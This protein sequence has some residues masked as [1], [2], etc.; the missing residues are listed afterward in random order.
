MNFNYKEEDCF[1]RGDKFLPAGLK[2]R[3]KIYNQVHGDAP[4]DGHKIRAWDPPLIPP[5]HPKNQS[6]NKNQNQA[7]QH[8]RP[9]SNAKT[10][11]QRYA[12]K[13]LVL[14][15]ENQNDIDEMETYPANDPSISALISEQLQFESDST[16]EYNEDASKPTICSFTNQ[17]NDMIRLIAEQHKFEYNFVDDER[18]QHFDILSARR[19]DDNDPPI[20]QHGDRVSPQHANIVDNQ[21]HHQNVNSENVIHPTQHQ[22]AAV[23]QELRNY[24]HNH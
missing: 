10:K 16:F 4:P 18:N 14:D 23:F 7:S 12:I 13:S 6:L 22:R 8:R 5:I 20:Q 2:R 11:T 17:S 9:F 15:E 1:L 21:Q 3:L 24:F 19:N